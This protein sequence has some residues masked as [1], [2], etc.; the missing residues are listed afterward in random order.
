MEELDIKKIIAKLFSLNNALTK[1]KPEEIR[2]E[3]GEDYNKD[4]GYLEKFFTC[5]LNEFKMKEE[6]KYYKEDYDYLDYTS[7]RMGYI[8]ITNSGTTTAQ[9]TMQPQYP[10]KYYYD[11]TQFITQIQSL[12]LFL[13]LEKDIKKL[14]SKN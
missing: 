5:N 8:V 13:E 12:L 1:S 11:K 7:T 10:K 9:S 6:D 3:I 2:V 14:L 4:I